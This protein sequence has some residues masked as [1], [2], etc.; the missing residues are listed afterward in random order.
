MKF[1]S[2]SKIL[3]DNSDNKLSITTERLIDRNC[4]CWTKYSINIDNDFNEIKNI[5]NKTE[6]QFEILYCEFKM[7]FKINYI[8]KLND[9][10]K[11]IK[12][13]YINDLKFMNDEIMK[14][15]NA[16]NKYKQHNRNDLVIKY[17][18]LINNEQHKM[19]QVNTN[20]EFDS[21]LDYIENLIVT[22]EK[23][24]M[25][26]VSLNTVSIWENSSI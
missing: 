1:R 15:K 6:E 16:I 4:R 17:T 26:N 23:E 25:N 19:F 20:K 18:N 8:T 13:D 2:N 22:N 21:Y 11:M 10:C 24:I 14:C 12:D 3:I 5:L 9:D 7:F